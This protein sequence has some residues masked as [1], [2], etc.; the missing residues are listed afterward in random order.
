MYG[1]IHIKLFCGSGSKPFP[2]KNMFFQ[3]LKVF[4]NFLIETFL[5]L[6]LLKNC[7]T[8]RPCEL[9]QAGYYLQ[10][11]EVDSILSVLAGHRKEKTE[12]E[13]K[14]TWICY[15]S[16]KRKSRLGGK[17]HRR[18]YSNLGQLPS[19]VAGV[20]DEPYSQ[21]NP[22]SG[23]AVQPASLPRLEPPRRIHPM[24]PGGPVWLLR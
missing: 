19:S 9:I 14:M 8:H 18:L 21:L 22:L 24:Q 3:R 17:D 11:R 13:D 1:L 16:S 20:L 23:V 6:P 5:V 15:F 12:R 10:H 7:S 2:G 4:V